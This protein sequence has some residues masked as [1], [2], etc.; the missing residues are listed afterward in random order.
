MQ[1]KEMYTSHQSSSLNYILEPE[2]KYRIRCC[3]GA[4]WVPSLNFDPAFVAQV[5]PQS[6]ISSIYTSYPCSMHLL[7]NALHDGIQ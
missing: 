6:C 3:S 1:I 2:N 4:G 5:P 7:L